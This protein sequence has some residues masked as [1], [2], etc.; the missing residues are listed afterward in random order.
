MLD[1]AHWVPGQDVSALSQLRFEEEGMSFAQGSRAIHFIMNG[2][3]HSRNPGVPESLVGQN[4]KKLLHPLGDQ[5][6]GEI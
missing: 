6:E 1:E 4:N 3:A 2:A 5:R